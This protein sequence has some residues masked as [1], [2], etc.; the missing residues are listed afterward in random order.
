M[1]V[2]G[3]HLLIESSAALADSTLRAVRDC[4]FHARVSASDEFDA[5]V[6]IASRT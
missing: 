2:P 6:V 1:V 3:G 5:V 4:G